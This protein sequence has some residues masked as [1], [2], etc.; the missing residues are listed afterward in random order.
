[1]KNHNHHQRA[2]KIQC[3]AATARR[4]SGL[5]IRLVI[6][7]LSLELLVPLWPMQETLA[8][9]VEDPLGR[10]VDLPENPR[11]IV[12]LAPSVTEILFALGLADR[13]AGVTRFSDYPPEA[14]AL[15]KVGSYVHLD[16]EKIVALNPDLCIAIKEG[17]PAA[18]IER[19]S[20]LGIPVYA[21]DPHNLSAVMDVFIDLGSLLNADERAAVIVAGM[22]QRIAAVERAVAG[23]RH[24]PRVFF[25]IGVSPI[26]S[27]GNATF[28]HELI[29][30][31]GGHNLAAGAVPYPRFS[32]EAVVALRPEVL[33]ITSMARQV[34][35]ERVKK[36]WQKWQEMPA[37]MNRRI[38]L[39][40]SDLLN[41]PSPRLVE[42][43][44]RLARLI[45]P[46]RFANGGRIPAETAP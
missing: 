44:E 19:I 33:I 4:S 28:I 13:V 40:D 46:D 21:V 6:I 18:V 34:V 26:V 15:P 35:F 10:S 25:Q 32:R 8:E 12:A 14:A 42:G 43:L 22:R 45:H 23:V 9:A 27:A 41:R 36:D 16:A 20:G 24:R 38:H 17:N 11:R 39:V 7:L 37:V 30:M 31:A 1:M 2:A 5:K 3:S 29:V